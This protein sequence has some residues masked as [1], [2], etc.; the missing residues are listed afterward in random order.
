M[1]FVSELLNTAD[2]ASLLEVSPQRVRSLARD[3][4]LPAIRAEGGAGWLFRASDVREYQERRAGRRVARAPRPG[5]DRPEEAGRGVQVAASR[6]GGD[7]V[8]RAEVERLRAENERW[9]AENDDLRAEVGGLRADNERLRAEV[10]DVR[11]RSEEL[12][13]SLQ[14]SRALSEVL[15]RELG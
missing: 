11:A 1:A 5:R 8:L 15:V 14:R 13:A 7:E 2:A 9:R 10:D 6:S 3:S 4:V 12:E